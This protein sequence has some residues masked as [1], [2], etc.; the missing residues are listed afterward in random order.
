MSFSNILFSIFIMS[1]IKHYLMTESLLK[2]KIRKVKYLK[3]ELVLSVHTA[4]VL[5]LWPSENLS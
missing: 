2:Y 1:S 4:P 5:N 3:E